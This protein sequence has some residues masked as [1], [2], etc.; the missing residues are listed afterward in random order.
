ML[1]RAGIA[2]L[3]PHQAAMCLLDG[4]TAWSETSILCHARSHLDATNPL[5]RNGLLSMVC[6]LEYAFQA[7][8]LHGA[9]R[10]G[11]PQPAGWLA[12]LRNVIIH[13]PRLDDPAVGRLRI[14]AVM[15]HCDPVGLV[16]GFC[17][18]ADSG[19]TLA[20]GRAT[21]VLPRPA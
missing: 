12:G 18:R 20:E 10:G 8:A 2:A 9:L 6:G 13:Q 14:E 4:V 7:A 15:E 16:Y 17:L 11:A 3:I 1:D 19:D 5:R 21:I